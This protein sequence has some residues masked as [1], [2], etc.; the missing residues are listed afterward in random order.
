VARI[1][2][3]W[4]LGMGMGHLTLMRPYI[5]ALLARGHQITAALRDASAAP[6]LLGH[7]D[8]TIT[9]A[10]I[11]TTP[12]AHPVSHV[13][14]FAEILH[15]IGFADP[16]ELA[17]LA[18]AWRV[19]FQQA[20]PDL[21]ICN[22]APTAL[23]ALRGIGIPCAVLGTGFEIPPDVHPW[24]S[25][26]PWEAVPPEHFHACESEVMAK[27]NLALD[28]LAAPQLG[29]LQELYRV[30]QVI[31]TEFAELDAYGPRPN[32]PYRGFWSV[33][34][35]ADV[36]WP[37]ALGPRIYGYLKPF[38]ALPHLLDL[39]NRLGS[40]TLIS[41]APLDAAPYRSFNSPSLRIETRFLN[42]DQAMRE[43]DFTLLN[44]THIL[45]ARSLLAAKPIL[46]FPFLLEF[47]H[48][49]KAV[50]RLGAGLIANPNQPTT[51]EPLLLRLGSVHTQ[52][53]QRFAARHASFDP[54]Q[55]V[56]AAVTELGRLLI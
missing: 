1:L 21:V 55:Q 14:S 32:I 39:L 26:R 36:D 10:P 8:I 6:Q 54:A 48:T 9:Q 47:F 44:G 3:A 40:P 35:G 33:D 13:A 5:E 45:S 43:C 30:G 52:A 56:H 41:M 46:L 2:F 27:A 28:A 37:S 42:L 25:L 50:E 12:V 19:A 11:K 20:K 17:A 29:S 49:A 4:E 23:L 53:A 7:L 31:L 24:P 18:T 34:P 15:N 16:G 22:H 51:F 38:P